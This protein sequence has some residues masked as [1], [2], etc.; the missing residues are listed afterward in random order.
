MNSLRLPPT[1][2]VDRPSFQPGITSPSLE[3]CGSSHVVGVVEFGSV[4]QL[5]DVVDRYRLAHLRT[6]PVA[7]LEIL[8]L[9][10]RWSGHLGVRW[11]RV[12][13]VHE[14]RNDAASEQ[15][16][17]DRC[18][19]SEVAVVSCRRMQRVWSLR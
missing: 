10:S 9:Q 17:H 18:R 4:F 13:A 7:D 16:Q 14:E 8:H 2:I 15:N 1:F 6:W 5:A 19:D 3:L 11:R 12:T